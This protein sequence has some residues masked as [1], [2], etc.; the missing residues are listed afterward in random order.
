LAFI[1]LRK[2]ISIISLFVLL[3]VLSVHFMLMMV[4]LFLIQS[5]YTMLAN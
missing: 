5:S 1:S 3:L 4:I 2:S